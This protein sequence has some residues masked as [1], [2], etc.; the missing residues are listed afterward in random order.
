MIKDNKVGVKAFFSTSIWDE[1]LYQAW[2]R[3]V[4]ELI[5]NKDQIKDCL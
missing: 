5:P 4:Q 3:I 2:S 1:T